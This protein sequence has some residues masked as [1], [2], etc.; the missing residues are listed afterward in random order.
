MEDSYKKIINDLKIKVTLLEDNINNFQPQVEIWEKQ[1]KE[2]YEELEKKLTT[3]L[4]EKWYFH[5]ILGFA[6]GLKIAL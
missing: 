4:Y 6:S 2:C 5:F 3:S 1:T